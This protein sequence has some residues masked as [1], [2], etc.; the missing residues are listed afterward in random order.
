MIQ[1]RS[2]DHSARFA[3][4]L[5]FFL[6]CGAIYLG[7]RGFQARGMVLWNRSGSVARLTGW[8]GRLLGVLLI[9]A[10]A[11]FIWSGMAMAMHP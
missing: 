2:A 5:I 8:P 9:A 10:G 3:A 11:W 4:I 1:Y 6:G 7:C